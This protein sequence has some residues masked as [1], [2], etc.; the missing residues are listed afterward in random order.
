MAGGM[1]L[2]LQRSHGNAYVSRL[3]KR[4]PGAAESVGGETGEVTFMPGPTGTEDETIAPGEKGFTAQMLK[5]VPTR[6]GVAFSYYKDA[7]LKP[8]QPVFAP[9][10]K[11]IRDAATKKQ[12]ADDRAKDFF[13]TP[14][15]T[16]TWE[17]RS[18]W[19]E[20]R[21]LKLAK[22][23]SQEQ[24]LCVDFSAGV[25]RANQM[26][27]S[28]AKL[29]SMQ[30]I[31]GVTSPAS[32]T[33][34]VVASL[35]EAEAIAEK[36]QVKGAAGDLDVPAADAQ[37][38]SATKELTIAQKKMS[39]AWMGVQ[40]TLVLDR[41]KSVEAEGDDERKRFKEIESNIATWKKLG[42]TID[43]SMAVM[44]VGMTGATEGGGLIGAIEGK[45]AGEGIPK[46]LTETS[47]AV[48]KAVGI[49]IPTSA[50]DVLETAAKIYY[51][52]ELETIRKTLETLQNEVNAHKAVAEELG[53]LQAL[54]E[55]RDATDDF[56]KKAEDLQKRLIARQQA[57]LK[58]GKQLDE[59]ATKD[60][61]FRGSAPGKGKE[62]FATVMV[63]TSAVR[64]VL[65]MAAGAK[66][67]FG[68]ASAQMRD[69]ILDM[70][71]VVGMA[72]EE[73]APLVS[74][75]NQ[76][77]TFEGNVKTIETDLGP[78]EAAAGS[79]MTKLGAGHKIAGE[80]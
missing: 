68:R 40:R 78:I 74:A 30:E 11:K 6:A 66:D 50:A 43:V 71:L 22:N 73:A 15:T 42:G 7:H 2:G 9:I 21:A 36:V 41:A 64:E 35:K 28:L 14:S 39:T 32:M 54:K 33:T 1:L 45:G 24:M 17:E 47:S 56:A 29:E 48:E 57:Y 51:F 65:A 70:A 60:P 34:A 67:G 12:E 10:D 80:Y 49:S 72:D 75:H 52:S 20:E 8:V 26:F 4:P 59:A 16:K 23:R 46:G 77:K 62:R 13:N 53:T 69:E 76:L 61:A 79:M 37:V 55:F 19:H 38:T 31:L 58:F 18:K 44:G 25:P 63:V 27:V 3:V 5:E